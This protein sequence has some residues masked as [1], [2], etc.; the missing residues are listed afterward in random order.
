MKHTGS[1][2][3]SWQYT[4]IL[5]L[6]VYAY[7]HVCM[8]L[9]MH[10]R[11]HVCMYDFAVLELSVYLTKGLTVLAEN[12]ILQLLRKKRHNYADCSVTTNSQQLAVHNSVTKIQQ[13]RKS[14]KQPIRNIVCIH[15]PMYVTCI[16]CVGVY[17]CWHVLMCW[18]LCMCWL[19]CM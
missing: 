11:I 6:Y 19:V 14:T 2:G 16:L 8:Y 18:H 1:R 15:V 10:V 9:C 12:M 17:L 7:T 13:H 4:P 5:I 3:N